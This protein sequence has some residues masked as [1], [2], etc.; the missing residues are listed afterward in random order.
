MTG[1]QTCALPISIAISL[2][3]T[4]L[5]TI[6]WFLTE[7]S[8]ADRRALLALE[9]KRHDETELVRAVLAK[10]QSSPDGGASQEEVAKE[11]GITLSELRQALASAETSAI[12]RIRLAD[13][14]EA[15]AKAGIA[16]ARQTKLAAFK[17]L[18]DAALAS[19]KYS[20]AVAHYR[21]AAVLYDRSGC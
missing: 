15:G 17:D 18:G 20:D 1:V 10:L 5:L 3:I 21:Q 7:R 2:V 9:K 16:Q 19:L 12:E 13:K 8:A 11:R 6:V 14:V 4:A